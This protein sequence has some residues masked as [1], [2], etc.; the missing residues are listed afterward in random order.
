MKQQK[1]LNGIIFSILLGSALLALISHNWSNLFVI[2]QV[3]GLSLVPVYLYRTFQI[4]ISSKLRLGI[5]LFL[6]STMFLG[7]VN[8]F[9]ETYKWWDTALHFTAG[10][11]LTVFGFALLRAIYSQSEL[12]STP[13]MTSFFAFCFTGT[14]SILWEIYEFVI[15]SLDWANN[16]MQPSNADTMSDLIVALLA[17]TIVCIF[18]YRY[19]KYNEKNLTGEMIAGTKQES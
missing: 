2:A 8:H 13:A 5:I 11:G 15:D 12:R 4:R 7:E 3:I 14:V 1:L 9:Y 6:F 18:G 10:L 19:L 17:A 16:K